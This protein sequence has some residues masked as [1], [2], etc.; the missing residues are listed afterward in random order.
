MKPDVYDDEMRAAIGARLRERRRT[1]QRSQREV[2]AA[3]GIRQATLSHYERGGRDLSVLT[4][5]RLA[6]A[7]GTSLPALVQGLEKVGA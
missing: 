7:L 3:A 6:A 5:L 2:A 1:E 4:A